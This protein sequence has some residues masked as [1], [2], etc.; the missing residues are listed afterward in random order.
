MTS[1]T[2]TS[3]ATP[4]AAGG[5]A[6][7]IQAFPS[8]NRDQMRSKLRQTASLFP[9]HTDQMGYGILNFGSVYNS[10]LNTSELV[11][12]HKIAIFP[13]PVQNILNIASESEVISA[14]VYDNLGRSIRKTQ[15][16]KSIKVEDFP[17]GTYYLKI[18]TKGKI[19]YEKFIKE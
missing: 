9:N 6:C 7:L 11:K 14:E 13:N 2:G 8:L 10:V 4:I 1:V 15:G 5:V 3:I 12:Q 18:Q 19:Y 17:K 16:Q